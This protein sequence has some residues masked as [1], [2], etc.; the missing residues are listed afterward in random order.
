MKLRIWI[1]A[2]FA[3]LVFAKVAL[4]VVGKLPY[5]SRS[6]A[7]IPHLETAPVPENA[8]VLADSE[9]ETV[10][11]QKFE[12]VFKVRKIPDA[13]IESFN[14]F[15]DG[16]VEPLSPLRM[17]DPQERMST[18]DLTEGRPNRRLVLCAFSTAAG[19]VLYEQGGYVTT[20]RLVVFD[21]GK[22]PGAW[23]A[24]LNAYTAN[25]LE[26]IREAVRQHQYFKNGG[27]DKI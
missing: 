3:L 16:K 18:D 9:V 6:T 25:T 23:G 21:F 12:L 19:L 20:R 2:F 26:A 4:Y 11:E 17:A 5:A 14:N 24:N 13:V 22:N 1:L 10:L 8:H 7:L 15:V 27:S